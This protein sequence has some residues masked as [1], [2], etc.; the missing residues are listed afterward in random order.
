MILLYEA[1][2]V[3]CEKVR[4]RLRPLF[5]SSYIEKIAKR[6]V[7]GQRLSTNNQSCV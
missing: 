2:Q 6:A 3:A 4:S 7:D 1:N 5:T